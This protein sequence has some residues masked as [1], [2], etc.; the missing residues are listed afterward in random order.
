MIAGLLSAQDVIEG[1]SAIEV[2]LGGHAS[3]T[4]GVL[5]RFMDE[6]IELFLKRRPKVVEA[7][8]GLVD[9]VKVMAE[10]NI[11]ALPIVDP[12]QHVRG[13][14]TLR[15][16]VT[17][18]GGTQGP[19]GIKVSEVMTPRAIFLS[20]DQKLF[21]AVRVMSARKIRRILVAGTSLSEGR[22]D[23]VLTNKDILR[24]LESG[25]SYGLLQPGSAMFARLG[26]LMT[27]GVL[28]INENDDVRAAAY[29]MMTMGVGGLAV[30]TPD[31][32]GIIT[33]RDL[34]HRLYKMKGPDFIQL[35][36]RPRDDVSERPGW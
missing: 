30:G 4:E 18:M 7:D 36:I 17:L 31:S 3:T 10:T 27:S 25:L 23:G 11:G 22:A 32:L 5:R 13:I 28:A 1:L 29:T 16:F 2:D 15:D 9:A 34:I 21:E 35:A 26:S 24:Y 8:V 6:A 33:E 19:L 20:P 12:Q 14:V